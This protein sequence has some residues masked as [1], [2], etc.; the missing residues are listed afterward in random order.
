MTPRREAAPA[1]GLLETFA[2]VFDPLF[3]KLN[4][5]ASFRR[6]LEGVLLPAERHKTLTGLANTAPGVGAQEARAQNLQW[7]LSESIGMPPRSISAAGNFWL[8]RRIPPPMR[9]ASWSSMK[10][11]MSKT[12]RTRPMW[13]GSIWAAWAR[14]PMGSCRSAF[15]GRRNTSSTRWR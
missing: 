9:T 12:G 3:A 13:G 6:Y 1:P 15:C 4:Q 14:S 2:H 7:F 11:G 10:R 8:R 5:R